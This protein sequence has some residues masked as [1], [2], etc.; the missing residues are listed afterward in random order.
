MRKPVFRVS[1]QVQHKLGY[2]AKDE[3]RQLICVSVF[4]YVKNRFSHD[5]AQINHQ[6]HTLSAQLCKCKCIS[7]DQ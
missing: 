3:K 5:A 7:V 2:T 6:I 4:T 1:G